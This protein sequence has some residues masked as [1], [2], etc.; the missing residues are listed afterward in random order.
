MNFVLKRLILLVEFKKI[1]KLALV[2]KTYSFVKE[3]EI[4]THIPYG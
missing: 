1:N 2:L 4:K 3:S